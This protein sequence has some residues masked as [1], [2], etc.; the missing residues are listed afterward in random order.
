MVH[1]RTVSPHNGTS[2]NGTS[3]NCTS[4][5][6]MSQNGTATQM[7]RGTEWYNLERY[8]YIMVN[9]TKWHSVTKRYVT[10]NRTCDT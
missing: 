6:C 7:V 9:F 2:H 5:N 10:G 8:S 4:Y 3:Q 1:H